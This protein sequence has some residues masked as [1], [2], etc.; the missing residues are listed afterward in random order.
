MEV[1]LIKQK[2]KVHAA[3]EVKQITK[4]TTRQL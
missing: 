1:K 4:L 2:H 3:S